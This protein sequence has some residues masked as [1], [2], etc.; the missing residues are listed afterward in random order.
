MSCEILAF[1]TEDCHACDI[2]KPIVKEA[3]NKV[4]IEVKDLDP[5][6]EIELAQ[7][8]NVSIV[9]T[10]VLLDLNGEFI[11]SVDGFVDDDTINSFLSLADKEVVA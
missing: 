9:P 2:L 3:A 6:V 10:F 11:E 5:T 1:S 4:G 8:Y 7:K